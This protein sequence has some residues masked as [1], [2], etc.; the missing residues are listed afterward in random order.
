[1]VPPNFNIHVSADKPLKP[2]FSSLSYIEII[3]IVQP[4]DYHRRGRELTFNFKVKDYPQYRSRF[5]VYLQLKI[6]ICS[7][8]QNHA[9]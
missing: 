1:M 4:I 3:Y 6:F 2:A 8:N 7:G 5:F 9:E